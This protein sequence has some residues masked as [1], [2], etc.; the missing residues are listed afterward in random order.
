M[1]APLSSSPTTP[2]TL[3]VRPGSQPVP[4]N[5]S[6]LTR[7]SHHA[8]R[9]FPWLP[10]LL[11]VLL[12]I[13]TLGFAGFYALSVWSKVPL[14]GSVVDTQGQAAADVRVQVGERRT[15]SDEFGNFELLSLPYGTTKVLAGGDQYAETEMLVELAYRTGGQTTVTVEPKT[16]AIVEGVVE[17]LPETPLSAYEVKVGS[18]L[19]VLNAQG[20]YRVEGVPLGGATL[21][22]Q[23]PTQTLT[24]SLEV[25][26]GVNTVPLLAFTT[27]SSATLEVVDWYSKEPVRG[28]TLTTNTRSYT[29]DARGQVVVEDWTATSE[30]TIRINAP[31][32]AEKAVVV[33]D[34]TESTLTLPPAGVLYYT[35][36]VDG[37]SRIHAANRDGSEAQVLTPEN[38]YVTGLRVESGEVYFTA[39]DPEAARDSFDLPVVNVYIYALESAT[40]RA[41]TNFRG[42]APVVG[43]VTRSL[44]RLGEKTTVLIEQ[45]TTG[46]QVS[47][48]PFAVS[49]PSPV[50]TLPR[51]A[52]ELITVSDAVL[53]PDGRLL[54]VLKQVNRS[55]TTQN[56]IRLV[57]LSG[58]EVSQNIIFNDPSLRI[59]GM[60]GF[61]ADSNSLLFETLDGSRQ[62][63]QKLT[64]G[65]GGTEEVADLGLNRYQAKIR[66]NT[67]YYLA[68]GDLRA[69]DIET[70]ES[71]TLLSGFNPSAFAFYGADKFLLQARGRLWY[72][73]ASRPENPALVNTPVHFEFL[74]D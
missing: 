44:P 36:L 57:S 70:L 33:S 42:V 66:E 65:Q 15:L 13:Q 27:P 8:H 53:S 48:Q 34:A 72:W 64:L 28:A 68:E 7:F 16:G 52:D 45:T 54:A 4:R 63:I 74:N 46:V 69:L 9:T 3:Q 30:N 60:L 32:Y 58:E 19:G 59:Q 17:L 38:L 25:E 21:S 22:V 11:V 37:V 67:V 24:Q 41:V 40:V 43:G 5:T 6:P 39:Y 35:A 50:L 49:E 71:T 31:D 55:G 18:V 73:D 47:L 10:W 61:G 56:S 23:T 51:E 62:L 1:P 14:R 29:T 2:R 20:I 12:I 26:P